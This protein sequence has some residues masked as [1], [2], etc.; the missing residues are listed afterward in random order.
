MSRAILKTKGC[1]WQMREM[2]TNLDAMVKEMD[3]QT[4]SL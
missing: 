2:K 3:L 1:G 4:L